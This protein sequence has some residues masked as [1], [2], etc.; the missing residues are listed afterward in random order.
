[1]LIMG[2]INLNESHYQGQINAHLTGVVWIF[3]GGGRVHD[4]G[5]FVYLLPYITHIIFE[6]FAGDAKQ[7]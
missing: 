1:M 3:L 5:D 2:L 4:Q 6:F 7:L